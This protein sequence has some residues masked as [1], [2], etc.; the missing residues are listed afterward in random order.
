MGG[1]K[2][3]SN[4]DAHVGGSHVCV[5]AYAHGW[6]GHTHTHK[7]PTHATQHVRPA[8]LF[9]AG[10]GAAAMPTG[11]AAAAEQRERAKTTTTFDSLR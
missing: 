8:P 7:P 11:A 5:C 9:C 1:Q 2:I 6:T 4:N 10:R 3:G